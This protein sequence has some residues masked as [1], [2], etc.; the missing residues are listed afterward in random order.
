M[1]IYKARAA[2]EPT[3]N[4]AALRDATTPDEDGVA[5]VGAGVRTVASEA[6]ADP[7]LE[8]E[9]AATVASAVEFDSE[10]T[11]GAELEED[12]EP[13][14]VAEELEAHEVCHLAISS[15]NGVSTPSMVK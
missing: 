1:S 6:P 7:E 15:S 9:E 10:P 14:V 4:A 3:A 8:P 5:V 2:M 13:A 11:A 12:E